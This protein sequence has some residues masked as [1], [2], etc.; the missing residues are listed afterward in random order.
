MVGIDEDTDDKKPASKTRIFNSDKEYI[1]P[2]SSIEPT[3]SPEPSN[4]L[5]H[6]KNTNVN[7][8]VEVMHRD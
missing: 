7:H 2:N 6:P 3:S 4:V 8:M 5:D 1:V